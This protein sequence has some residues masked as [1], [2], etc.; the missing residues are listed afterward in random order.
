M[1]YTQYIERIVKPY[2]IGLVG[3]THQTFASPSC[4]SEGES[5]VQ[6]LFDA[7]LN[8]SCKFIRFST[9]EELEAH[10]KSHESAIRSGAMI[11]VQKESKAKGKRVRKGKAKQNEV[12]DSEGEGAMDTA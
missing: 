8:D 5:E 1:Q 6:R 10:I 11:L 2:R 7:L 12:V 4:L 3:W 9:D